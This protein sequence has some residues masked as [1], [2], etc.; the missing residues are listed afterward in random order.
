MEIN[1][2]PIDC[3]INRRWNRVGLIGH[4]HPHCEGIGI[5]WNG[6]PNNHLP[7][8]HCGRKCW[9]WCWLRCRRFCHG[10]RPCSHQWRWFFRIHKHAHYIRSADNLVVVSL[11]L[12]GSRRC[13]GC[14]LLHGQN[15]AR[16]NTLVVRYFGGTRRYYFICI[17][18]S[19]GAFLGRYRRATFFV[20]ALVAAACGV[21]LLHQIVD[22]LHREVLVL[23][24]PSSS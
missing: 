18:R 6:W 23:H 9:R 10:R 19:F 20:Q 21:V 17:G 15:W 1:P 2:V 11:D 3:V 8:G 5:C 14:S 7:T 22:G 16:K 13:T 4:G 24:V 12:L